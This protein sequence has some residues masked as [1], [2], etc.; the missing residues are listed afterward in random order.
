MEFEI[1]AYCYSEKADVSVSCGSTV[2]STNG[3]IDI[4]DAEWIYVGMSEAFWENHCEFEPGIAKA[5]ATRIHD[6]SLTYNQALWSVFGSFIL[7]YEINGE[8]IALDFECDIN[9]LMYSL[10]EA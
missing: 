1:I 10:L 5:E 2:D 7:A 4:S 8:K 9:E 3:T 6:P